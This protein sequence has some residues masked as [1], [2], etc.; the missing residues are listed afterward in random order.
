MP[1]VP[2]SYDSLRDFLSELERR[3]WL[4]RVSA[5][6]NPRLEMTEIATRVLADGGPALLFE[7]VAEAGQPPSEIPALANLFGTVERVA[8]GLGR[9][10]ADL[11]ALGKMLAFLERPTPPTSLKEAFGLWPTLKTA[12]VRKPKTV[13]SAPCQQVVARGDDADLGRLPLQ[14]CWPGEPAPLITWPLVVTRAPRD[15]ACAA[16]NIGI[17]RMQ[18]TG[19][20]S[21]IMRWLPARGGAAHFEQWRA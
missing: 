20:R 16:P 3:Q 4:A 6:V 18:V 7:R 14:T 15:D 10:P 2:A 11:R 19:P 9:E 12:L 8:L 5:P 1:S 13:G 17:Y 21:T